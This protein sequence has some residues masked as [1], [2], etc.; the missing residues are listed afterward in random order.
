MKKIFLIVVTLFSVSFPQITNMELTGNLKEDS[1]LLLAKYE[2]QNYLNASSLP[3]ASRKSGPLAGLFSF[4]LPGAGQFYTE[5]YWKAGLFLALEAAFV[6]TAIVYEN[7]G[8][9]QTD[10]YQNYANNGWSVVKYAQA[11]GASSAII[12]NDESLPAWKR[13]NWDSLHKY[14]HGSHKLAP[15][16]DQQYFEM[17]G[18]Y[19]QFAPGWDDY[20]GSGPSPN[21]L[22]YSEMRGE[23]NDLYNISSKAV[24]GIYV[25]HFLSI[26]DAFWSAKIYNSKLNMSIRIDE[27]AYAYNSK[28][29][30]QFN[31][32]Y[33]F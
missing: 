7:K 22:H 28:L 2:E 4:V 13:V 18:K 6:T 8:D 31:I 11:I 10:T 1:D 15:Y 17:I 32:K 30:P 3:A 9:K 27:N 26:L 12:S 23:A 19:H 5:Q 25:N 14:E 29:V 21:F 16:G 20:Q 33:S 24:I